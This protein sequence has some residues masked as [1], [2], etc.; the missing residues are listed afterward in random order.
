[1]IGNV[2]KRVV[3]LPF[4]TI[5]IWSKDK[6]LCEGV[7]ENGNYK[8]NYAKINYDIYLGWDFQIIDDTYRAAQMQKGIYLGH[9]VGEPC[10]LHILENEIY[11]YTEKREFYPKIV[12][13][14]V[15]KYIFTK[16]SLDYNIL[17]MKATMLRKMNHERIV[18]LF[19]KGRSGKTTLAD[20][21]CK[22]GYECLSNTH[23]MI[24]GNY[25]WGINSW[26]RRRNGIEH[27]EI[28]SQNIF[29]DGEIKH[30]MIVESNHSSQE[31]KIK[32]LSMDQKYYYLK[33]FSAAINN[34]D[35]KEEV[36]DY[37]TK[38][39][40]M[41]INYL[42]REDD[43]VKS[44]CEKM[45]VGISINSLEIKCIEMLMGELDDNGR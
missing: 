45:V 33:N 16:V 44:F 28:R 17:H 34:Y 32:E 26:I 23:C 36:F 41:A 10:K 11:I 2:A 6:E 1:M 14:F 39:E 8:V 18:L 5:T 9:N 15:L 25:V 3:K 4:G 42:K 40:E 30:C 21:L 31:L 12:W 22:K 43:L 27:Y 37:M 7:L 24:D 38:D 13:S 29:F 20:E 19:G 35:L